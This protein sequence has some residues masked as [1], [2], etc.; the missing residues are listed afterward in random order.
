M[1]HF[2]ALKWGGGGSDLAL[3]VKLPKGGDGR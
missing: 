2:S 3:L 1:L